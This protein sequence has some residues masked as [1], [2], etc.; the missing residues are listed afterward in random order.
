MFFLHE[1]TAVQVCEGLPA[2]RIGIS[3]MQVYV[4]I[5]KYIYSTVY[6]NKK[7]IDM[8]VYMIYI[9]IYVLCAYNMCISVMYMCVYLCM[10]GSITA[11][12]ILATFSRHLREFPCKQLR[13]QSFEL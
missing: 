1:C 7:H 12:S 8:Y 13:A 11:S 10:H 2:V 9:Y 6:I 4:H 3:A 5:Y